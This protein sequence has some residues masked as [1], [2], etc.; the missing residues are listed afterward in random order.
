MVREYWDEADKVPTKLVKLAAVVDKALNACSWVSTR[1]RMAPAAQRG[2]RRIVA[3]LEQLDKHIFSSNLT[4][5]KYLEMAVAYLSSKSHEVANISLMTIAAVDVFEALKEKRWQSIYGLHTVDDISQ[6]A[7]LDGSALA[8]AVG[9]S[10][11]FI[12]ER[13]EAAFAP[14]DVLFFGTLVAYRNR[15]DPAV[16]YCV[17]E[18]R[19]A[20][21]L[22]WLVIEG[23]T[24]AQIRA[25]FYDAVDVMKDDAR[26]K[27][28]NSY[29]SY[30]EE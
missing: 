17:P 21:D 30:V 2:S 11:D 12:V 16:L 19:R 1:S 9:E 13:A 22:G 4:P 25:R 29:F 26:W 6:P 28:F 20:I 15:I 14:D 10:L 23:H 8:A 18:L 27:W 24:A 5:E 3:Y 7:D